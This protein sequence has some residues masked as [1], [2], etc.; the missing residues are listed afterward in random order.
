MLTP[1]ISYEVKTVIQIL[2]RLN[3]VISAAVNTSTNLVIGLIK[4]V[5]QYIDLKY[6]CANENKNMSSTALHSECYL[7]R[8]L[9]T[10]SA[11]C[12]D[13]TEPFRVISYFIHV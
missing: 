2:F 5:T 6:P 3:L 12:A 9:P 10:R 13:R 7:S 11:H 8:F 4:S 1:T